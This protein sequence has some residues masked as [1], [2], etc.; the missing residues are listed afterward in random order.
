MNLNDPIPGIG[1]RI[2][3]F[4]CYGQIYQTNIAIKSAGT[5]TR[6]LGARF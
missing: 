1:N 4:K 2:Y 3:V 6:D 5:I